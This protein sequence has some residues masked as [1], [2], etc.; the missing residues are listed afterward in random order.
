M[1]VGMSSSPA[2]A[3]AWRQATLPP[4]KISSVRKAA[5]WMV[6]GFIVTSNEATL[7]LSTL[8]VLPVVTLAPK[9]PLRCSAERLRRGFPQTSTRAAH[10]RQRG[11]LYEIPPTPESPFRQESSRPRRVRSQPF[12]ESGASHSQE[13]LHQPRNCGE[14]ASPR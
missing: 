7:D 1:A 10:T 9:G 4:A 11:P 5:V 12:P 3:L 2:R 14:L 6:L 8:L 13:A